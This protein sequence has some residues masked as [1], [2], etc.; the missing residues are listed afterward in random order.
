MA[1]RTLAIATAVVGAFMASYPARADTPNF[2]DLSGYTPV[3]VRDY[4]IAVP[5]LG[6][7]PLATVY[8]LAIAITRDDHNNAI[9]IVMTCDFVSAAAQCTG[10]PDNPPVGPN[11][12]NWIATDT[13]PKRANG[14][15]ASGNKLH[16][17][18]IKTLPALH[19]IAV[20]G[21]ICGV[22]NDGIT[23]CKDSQARG[24][25]LSKNGWTWPAHL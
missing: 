23:A 5:N 6:R 16:G 9:A 13:G 20:D 22:D 21:V 12:V 3:D 2:P 15:I 17:H 1:A 24:F 11:P 10:F 7:E 4:T 25:V 14:A 19:S 8:F 18:S